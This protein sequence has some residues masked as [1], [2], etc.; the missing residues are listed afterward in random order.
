[1]QSLRAEV[2]RRPAA[3][4][5]APGHWYRAGRAAARAAFRLLS[6][7]RLEGLASVPPSGPLIVVANHFSFVDPPL[8]AASIPR[9]LSFIAKAELWEAAPSRLFAEG[10]GL[11]PIRRGEADL[12][13]LRSA[14]GVLQAGGAIGFFPEGTR[15]REKPKQLK[16]G[17][18]GVALVARHSGAAILPVGIAGT[19][20]IETPRDIPLQLGRR[21]PFTVRIG[22]P[23]FLERRPGRADLQT[24]VDGIMLR[25]AELLP[26]RY[27]PAYAGGSGTFL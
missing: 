10:M 23:F 24:D 17:Q 25:I 22:Q 13:A 7:W 15:G 18:P 8:L 9:P 2:R 19:D 12:G 1:M 14:L 5:R 11:L 3:A 20:V 16:R 27:R 4:R 21:P 6:R 26:E